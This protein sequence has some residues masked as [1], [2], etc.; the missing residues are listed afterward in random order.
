MAS[1]S[2]QNTPA[3]KDTSATSGKPAAKPVERSRFKGV[4]GKLV[5]LF[6]CAVLVSGITIGGV[7]YFKAEDAMQGLVQEK[8]QTLVEARKTALQDYFA[9]IKEDLSFVSTNPNTI[10]ALQDFKAGWR[11]VPGDRTTMLQDAYIGN[12][13]HPTGKKEEL[14]K[15]EDGSSYSDVHGK[16]HPWFRQFLRARL[17]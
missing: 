2:A 10:T 7:S 5:A 15:A 4:R 14:D 9:S 8:L 1:A 12:N 16:Y 13:P 6:A 11:S 17:L 3:S